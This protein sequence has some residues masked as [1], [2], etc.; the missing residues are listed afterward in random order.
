MRTC[1]WCDEPIAEDEQTEGQRHIECA[2]RSVIGSVGHLNQRCSCFGGTEEDPPGLTTREA[3]K[4]AHARFLAMTP[5][6]T[7]F[8]VYERPT[9][10]PELYV[11]RAQHVMRNGDIVPDAEP[12]AVGTLEEVR[13]AVPE[14]STQLAR[15]ERDE[16][17]IFE[18]WI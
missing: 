3:A 17:Q 4:A 1:T 18:V 6:L 10:Y 16:P 5:K 13:R 12:M 7:T 2:A 15:D 11:L 8:V 9:D 14:G